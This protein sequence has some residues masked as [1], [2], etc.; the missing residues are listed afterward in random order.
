MPAHWWVELILSPLV[1]GALSLGMIRGGCVPRRQPCA[2][3]LMGRA[4]LSPSLLFGLGLLRS[5]GWGQIFPKW[6]PSEEFTLIF[7]PQN[8]ASNVLPLQ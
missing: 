4:V 7:I 2:C 3:L 6:P 5:D 8:F 1:G